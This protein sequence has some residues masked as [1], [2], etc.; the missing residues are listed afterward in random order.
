[1]SDQPDVET[2]CWYWGMTFLGDPFLTPT[3]VRSSP[4]CGWAKRCS[5]PAGPKRKKPGDGGSLAYADGPIFLLKGGHTCE[6]Y[7]YDA[8]GN[9]WFARDPLP[10][11]GRS[12]KKKRVGAGGA[13]AWA[14]STLVAIKGSHTGEFWEY[15][16]N[17]VGSCAWVQRGD[18]GGKLGRGSCLATARSGDSLCVYL[19]QGGT[20]GFNRYS[21]SNACWCCVHSANSNGQGHPFAG[22]SSLAWDGANTV[23]ALKGKCNELWAYDV[24]RDSW[25]EKPSLPMI[26]RSGREHKVSN[27][28]SMVCCDGRLFATKG[29][30]TSD[31][32]VYDCRTNQWTEGDD[33]PLG[34]SRKGIKIGGALACDPDQKALYLAKGNRTCEFW[35]YSLDSIELGVQEPSESVEASVASSPLRVSPNPFTGFTRVR[36]MVR[37]P[38]DVSLKL[39]D[40]TGKLVC[41]LAEGYRSAG[42]YSLLVSRPRLAGSGVYLLK[43]K[44]DG[45]SATLKL[46]VQ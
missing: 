28:A 24:V 5:I 8:G 26:G 42:S 37:R 19:A 14:E 38:G 44:S 17:T 33:V 27:G 11:T 23:Y 18:Y 10:E 9:S 21:W 39:F 43:L 6:F 40:V 22:G 12:G 16:P 3:S 35:A 29:G 25:T 20:D 30:G 15:Y 13:I 32:W 7:Q 31:L 41:T 45:Q 36:W 34:S 2:E 1:M 4:P 46:V